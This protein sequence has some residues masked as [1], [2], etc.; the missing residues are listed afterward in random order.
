MVAG[1]TRGAGRGIAVELGAAGATVYVTGRT[2]RSPAIRIWPARK[3]SRRPP[4]WLR[5]L[6]ARALPC[7]WT[8]WSPT[9]SRRWSPASAGRSAARYPRQRYLGRRKSVR[10]EQAGLGTLARK[11]PAH[12]AAGDRHASDHRPLCSAADDREARR[13]AGGDDRRH[14]GIQCHPLPA[15]ALLRSRQDRR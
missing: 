14:G 7:R 5:R 9:R 10:M 15:L 12:A 4:N 13:S 6:A 2:T 1:A 11:R 3:P 8:I